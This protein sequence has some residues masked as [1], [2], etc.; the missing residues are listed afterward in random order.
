VFYP[1]RYAEIPAVKRDGTF[2]GR[3]WEKRPEKFP[4]GEKKSAVGI[5]KWQEKPGMA[6]KLHFSLYKG[7][8]FLIQHTFLNNLVC[9]HFAPHKKLFFVPLRSCFTSRTVFVNS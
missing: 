6:E 3:G 9:G 5:G 1:I 4:Y 8:F 2:H 7:N